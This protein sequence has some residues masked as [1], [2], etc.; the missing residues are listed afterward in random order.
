MTGPDPLE[1][2]REASA[3][4]NSGADG[5]ELEVFPP[6]D[7][8][9]LV[10]MESELGPVPPE[11][12]KLLAFASGFRVREGKEEFEVMFDGGPAGF[13]EA[14]PRSVSLMPD[15]F[16]NEWRV[17]VNPVT[18]EW[19]RVYFTCHDPAVIVVQS[20]SLAEFLKQLLSA[21]SGGV[22]TALVSASGDPEMR[23]FRGRPQ[24]TPAAEA[25]QAG[26]ALIEAAA[27]GLAP[28][29]YVADLRSAGRGEGFEWDML[30]DSVR[31][32][33][34][35]PEPVWTLQPGPRRGCLAAFLG[36]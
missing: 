31:I 6:V 14:F 34:P 28:G 7:A 29:S 25:G 9:A 2:L 11:I 36:R 15:G 21:P 13:E 33:R 5:R 35:G 3:R 4:W 27:R 18:G 23:I 17:D 32:G 24:V 20:E 12:A 26:D 8:A 10:R 16:G 30:G 1:T 22:A 19:A